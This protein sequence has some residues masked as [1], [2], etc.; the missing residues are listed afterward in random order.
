MV[1]VEKREK[2]RR[3]SYSR[4]EVRNTDLYKE[5][6]YY[7]EAGI[8]LWLNG[9]PSSSEKIARMVHEENNY[10]RDYQADPANRICSIG[11]DRIRKK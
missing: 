5:L 9:K 11:F 10:M 1:S 6:S 2:Q 8:S 4:E 7:Q 3:N